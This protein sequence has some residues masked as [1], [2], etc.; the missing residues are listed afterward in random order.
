MNE[1]RPVLRR[2]VACRK[3]LD[4]QQLWRVIR[5][6]REGVLLD[7]GM[8]RSAYLCPTE[9]CLDE[10]RRRKRLNKALRCQV[11]DSVIATLQERLS[12]QRDSR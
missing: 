9:A 7:R 1:P 12:F 4:R 8:G 5:D 3:L 11:P 6:H 10:A 2:C